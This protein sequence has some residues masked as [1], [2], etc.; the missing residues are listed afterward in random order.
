MEPVKFRN[1][2]YRFEKSIETQISVD[3]VP[4]NSLF[5]AL[6]ESVQNAIDERTLSGATVNYGNVENGIFLLD[7][8]HG[9]NFNDIWLIGA[10]G[11]RGE[12]GVVGQHGEGEIISF[13][14]AARVG[15]DKIMASK[16]WLARGRIVPRGN[17]DVLV[18]DLFKS[19]TPRKGTAWQYTSEDPTSIQSEFTQAWRSFRQNR[20]G[21]KQRLFRG[22]PGQLYAR[23]MKVN[24]MEDLAFGY[25]LD[26][27]LGRDRGGYTWEQIKSEVTQILNKMQGEDILHLL[28]KMQYGY[29]P[30]E[31]EL[32]LFLNPQSV[33]W[34]LYKYT[35]SRAK[36]RAAWADETRRDSAYVSDAR[37]RGIRVFRFRQYPP[38]WFLQAVPHV[39]E[40]VTVHPERKKNLPGG[41][42]EAVEILKELLPSYTERISVVAVWTFNDSDTRACAGKDVI[43]LSRKGM[44]GLSFREFVGLF[45]HECSHIDTG[46]S[47]CTRAHEEGVRVIMSR[48]MEHL[49]LSGGARKLYLKAQKLFEGYSGYKS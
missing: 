11:K 6:R 37:E 44:K 33:S 22:E 13:L 8:G 23:G 24:K 17:H 35:G 12:K 1:R 48:L 38:R 39:S 46:A 14:V 26:T 10:S 21:R 42:K 28:D 40:V 15:V 7:N 2:I 4:S 36:N 3:Y 19:R 34:A 32:E 49:V 25:D 20:R 47:D 41:L 30:K 27:T 5:W 16:N 31:G 18:I 9:V 43:T 45:A 29:F